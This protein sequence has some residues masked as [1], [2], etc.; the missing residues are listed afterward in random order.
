MLFSWPYQAISAIAYIHSRGIVHGDVGLHNF[1]HDDGRLI[2]CEFAGSGM[3]VLLPT[4]GTGVRHANPRHSQNP[5]PTAEDDVFA[6]GAVL[7]ELDRG[8]RLF[9]GQSS[10]DIY[11]HLRD[12][13]LPDLSVVPVPLRHI[14]EKCWT[15]PGCRAGDALAESSPLSSQ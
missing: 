4:I 11:R 5:H 6:L 2:L 12:Q 13:E 1:I 10:R 7:Y 14:I 9:E 3:D 15:L 8:K